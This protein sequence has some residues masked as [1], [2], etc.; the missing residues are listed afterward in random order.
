MATWGLWGEGESTTVHLQTLIELSF[1]FI[2]N[3]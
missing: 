3:S 1:M 2:F